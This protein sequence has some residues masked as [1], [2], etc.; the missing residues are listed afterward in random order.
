MKIKRRARRGFS[1]TSAASDMA[2]LLI[3][4]F[5]VIAG[6]N[7]NYGFLMN[8]PAKNSTRIVLK[9]NLLCFSL[10]SSGSLALEGVHIR[11]SE[12]ESAIHNAVKQRPDLSVVLSV[13]P[14]AP[15]QSVVSFVDI[16]QRL[17]VNS[18]SFKMDKGAS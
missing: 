10:D 17:K 5:L 14:E 3:I 12:A 9:D 11:L 1:E 18:F 8:L 4:Y 15:W 16:A 2:F 7:V 6:F 13:D